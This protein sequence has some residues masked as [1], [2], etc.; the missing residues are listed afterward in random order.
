M[1]ES[2]FARVRRVLSGSVEDAVDGLERAGGASVMREAMR[3]VD[4]A[5][6]EVRATKQAAAARRLLAERQTR[7]IAERLSA[8]TDK[9]RFALAEGREDLAE[10]AVTRQI[11]LEAEAERLED[12]K[13]EAAEEEARLDE[14][15]AA[16]EARAQNMRDDLKAYEAAQGEADAM[17]MKAGAAAGP[18]ARVDRRVDRA[19]A[20]FERVMGNASAKVGD[21]KTA[22]SIAEIDAM[23][24][25]ATVAQRLAALKATAPDRAA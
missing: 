21:P 10:A 6:D 20:A 19:E 1:A 24:K 18:A 11:A 7:M 13:G 23:Q 12:V 3:E 22:R 2:I 8:L 17:A 15:I 16:L 9:A 25:S 14:C 5:L 4:R